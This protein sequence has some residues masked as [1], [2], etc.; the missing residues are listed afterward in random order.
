MGKIAFRRSTLLCGKGIHV[1]F[2]LDGTALFGATLIGAFIGTF[3][4]GAVNGATAVTVPVTNKIIIPT[5]MPFIFC[6]P[7][8]QYLQDCHLVMPLF[9][10]IFVPIGSEV[11][12]FEKIRI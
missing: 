4:P 6:S 12:Q 11:G 10:M 1:G 5:I 8:H 7:S 2:V 9:D 3:G